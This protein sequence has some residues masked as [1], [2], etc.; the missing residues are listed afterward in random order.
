MGMKQGDAQKVEHA[1]FRSTRFEHVIPSIATN[2]HSE[3]KK[4]APKGAH[5]D[6]AKK[7]RVPFRE[8]RGVEGGLVM[9]T[10]RV[11]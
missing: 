2:I 4:E 7:F 3:D 1:R 10:R 5:Q 6:G 11:V 8:E 9:E